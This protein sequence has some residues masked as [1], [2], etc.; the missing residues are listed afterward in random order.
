MFTPTNLGTNTSGHFTSF[1]KGDD[2]GFT[3]N[4]I[5]AFSIVFADEITTV[6]SNM[7]LVLDSVAVIDHSTSELAQDVVSSD[8]QTGAEKIRKTKTSS[9]IEDRFGPRRSR[10]DATNE[11]ASVDTFF[12]KLADA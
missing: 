5:D 8:S 9:T 12:G 3:S 1:F 2:N 11:I 10:R 7:N 4:P 6:T